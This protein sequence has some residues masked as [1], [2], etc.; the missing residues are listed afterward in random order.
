MVVAENKFLVRFVSEDMRPWPH[1]CLGG[2]FGAGRDWGAEGCR[3]SGGTGVG[4]GGNS[5]PEVDVFVGGL[6]NVSLLQIW[7]LNVSGLKI[8]RLRRVLK[9]KKLGDPW[10]GQSPALCIQVRGCGLG[11]SMSACHG[12]VAGV[13]FGR[14]EGGMGRGN[15][16]LLCRTR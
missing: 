14:C 5:I 2:S 1:S 15:I 16:G 3:M 13:T 10:R 4:V 9:N 11:V 8:W 7:G 6:T 12:G